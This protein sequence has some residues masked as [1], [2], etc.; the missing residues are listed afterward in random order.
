MRRNSFI[1]S[2][3][4]LMICS[5]VL[6]SSPQP[7]NAQDGTQ[8]G[9]IL[10]D[11]AIWTKS[12]SPY[13]LTSTVQ[14]SSNSTLTI[15]A[16]V[17]I[18]FMEQATNYDMFLV[19]GSIIA[20]GTNTDKI[21]FKGNSQTTFFATT[22]ETN[23][24]FNLSYCSFEEGNRLFSI[25]DR[26]SQIIF[27]NCV[28]KDIEDNSRLV[29]KST[30]N[31]IEY[32]V[33]INSAG[34]NIVTSFGGSSTAYYIQNNLVIGS[35]DN[36]N[37]VNVGSYDQ[38]KVFV[39]YNS[40]INNNYAVLS[41]GGDYVNLNAQNNYWGTTNTSVIDS[42]INDMKD[43]I[44]SPGYVTY[45]PILTEPDINTPTCITANATSGGIITPSGLL[46]V[47]YGDNQ[48][49]T[50]TA[51]NGYYISDVLVNG[52]SVGAVTTYTVLNIQDITTIS[53]IFAADP[54]P[55]PTPTSSPTIAPTPTP[56]TNPTQ[57]PT[58]TPTQ[59]PSTEPSPTPTVPEFPALIAV[60]I[61]IA[62]TMLALLTKKGTAIRKQ[63]TT[64]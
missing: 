3:L 49:F 41:Q 10:W 48:T 46:D 4:I 31:Y 60:T 7:S 36:E 15:E 30:Q 25:V 37:F 40:F 64:K 42:L 18:S 59:T 9:G 62:I 20:L 52:S 56:T 22:G 5:L 13:R 8:V 29:Q 16:G 47:K 19:Q 1:I 23:K 35:S 11:N 12:G 28:V 17:D 58:S 27:R 61:L 54:T 45:L 44:D 33:F 2:L 55:T 34:F 24:K 57:Q 63:A 26:E 43:N 51:N 32:N 6:V 14:I 39:N 38:T 21:T 53:A 50:I